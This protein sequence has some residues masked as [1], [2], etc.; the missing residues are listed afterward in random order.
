MF[1]NGVHSATMENDDAEIGYWIGVPY[2]GK[3]LIPEAVRCLL[4]RC[5]EILGVQTVW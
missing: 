3:G 4:Y 5:F 2:W 1:G